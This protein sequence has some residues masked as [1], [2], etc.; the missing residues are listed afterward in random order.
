MTDLEIKQVEE[1]VN[2]KIKDD[3]KVD[4]MIVSLDEAKQ[5]HAIGLFDEKYAEKVSIYGIGP[6][7]RGGYYSLEFCGGPHVEHTGVIGKIE[8][9]KEEAISFG[10]RRIYAK[11]AL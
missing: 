6:Q 10:A 2:Q 9:T 11:I 4:H 7:S 1:L 8:I 3:L 5:M